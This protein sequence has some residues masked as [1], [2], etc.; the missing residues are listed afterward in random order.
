M[1]QQQNAIN[2]HVIDS[3]SVGAKGDFGHFWS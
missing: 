3:Q 1:Q 2:E